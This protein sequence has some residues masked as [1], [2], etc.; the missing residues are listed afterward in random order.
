MNYDLS[1]AIGVLW[2]QRGVLKE[3]ISKM[4]S[5]QRKDLLED[6]ENRKKVLEKAARILTKGMKK[7][8]VNAVSVQ[9]GGVGF[10]GPRDGVQRVLP[11]RVHGVRQNDI[12]SV[13]QD[14]G[15]QGRFLPFPK[16]ETKPGG[17]R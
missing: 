10:D 1:Y 15:P 7:E 5:S 4:K 16:E 17:G 2:R 14:E 8:E 9:S 12:P 13:S 11:G 3:K 6:L